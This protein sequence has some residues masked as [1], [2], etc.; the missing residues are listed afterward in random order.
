MPL[1]R[2]AEFMGYLTSQEVAEALRVP[3]TRIR[4]LCREGR[5]PGAL[6]IGKS[7][8]IPADIFEQLHAQVA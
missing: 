1:E 8:R 7:W 5:M 3:E 4:K 2:F 6:R